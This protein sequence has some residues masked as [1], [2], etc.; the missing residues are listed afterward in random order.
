M[1]F[2]VTATPIVPLTDP[3]VL[4]K[5]E[6]WMREQQ[7]TGRIN[8]AYGLVGGGGCSVMDVASAEELHEYTALCPIGNYLS[9]DI[10]PLIDLDTSFSMGREHLPD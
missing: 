8:A 10:K 7:Q 4:Q 3:I 5:L 1:K 9:F 6:D 2:L